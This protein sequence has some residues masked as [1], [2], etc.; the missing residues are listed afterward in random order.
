MYPRFFDRR[1]G[2]T[3]RTAELTDRT[4]GMTDKTAKL[5][6][7]TDTTR[8]RIKNQKYCSKKCLTNR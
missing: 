8:K 2:M 7:R 3:D 5:M 1:V 4:A 6:D